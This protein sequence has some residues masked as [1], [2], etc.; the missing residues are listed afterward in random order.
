MPKRFEPTSRF[1]KP[2]W[3]FQSLLAQKFIN[4]LMHEGRKRTAEGIFYGAM[5]HMAETVKERSPIEVFTEAVENVKPV[6]EVRSRRVGGATYQVPVE[7]KPNRRQSLAIRWLL[8]AARARKGKPMARR[9]ADELLDAYR[10]QGA[11]YTAREN[12][13]RMAEANKAFA[14]FAW[15]R[16]G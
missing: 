4:A 6:V 10:K 8:A 7:V 11:A 14:H 12:I 3:R 2:D 13:H 15:G 5:D 1:V 9:L 16:K